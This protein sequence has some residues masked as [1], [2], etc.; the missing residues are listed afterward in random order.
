MSVMPGCQGSCGGVDIAYPIGIGNVGCFRQGFQIACMNKGSAGEMPILVGTDKRIQVLSLSVSPVPEAQVL[1]PVA[2]QC[3]NSNGTR[4]G[5]Y[6]GTVDFNNH[7]VYRISDTRNELYVLGC[8]TLIYVKGRKND[9]GRFNYK[10]Y[11]GCVNACPLSMAPPTPRTV[12][13][14]V[15]AAATSTSFR[16]P[17]TPP[18]PWG[19][20]ATG[21]T[22]ARS[23]APAT[24]PSS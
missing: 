14:R 5:G 18:C 3:F 2:W 15:A 19:T 11:S 20:K 6:Y 10:L 9:V 16:A 7:S 4:T 12:C 22:R 24:T 8:N 17:Q 23:T 21:R 1:L 13:A